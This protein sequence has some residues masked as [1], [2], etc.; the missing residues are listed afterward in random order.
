[1]EVEV[2]SIRLC[3]GVAAFLSVATAPAQPGPPTTTLRELLSKAVQNNRD[4]LAVRR[5]IEEARGLLR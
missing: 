3:F 2:S 4:L 1:L 5:R